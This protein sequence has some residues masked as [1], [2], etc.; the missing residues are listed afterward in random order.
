MT[1]KEAITKSPLITNKM[2][3]HPES[4]LRD[5]IKLGM[6]FF[7]I[8]LLIFKCHTVNVLFIA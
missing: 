3:K 5:V 7:M 2:A 1:N 8:A 6:Y 4:K